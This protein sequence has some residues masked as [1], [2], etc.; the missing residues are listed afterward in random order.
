LPDK[1]INFRKSALIAAA[2]VALAACSNESNSASSD[3][4][5]QYV[6]A[7]SWQPAFCETA[8][9]KPECKS[10][11]AD[12]YD[13]SHFSLHGL[14]PQ[15][16]TNVYCGIAEAERAKDSNGRWRDLDAPLIE[17]PLWQDVQ[18]IM[19]GARSSLHKH[20]WIKHGTCAGVDINRYFARSLQL[21]EAINASGLQQL[22][23][24]NTGRTLSAEDI[25]TTFSQSFGEGAGDRLRVSCKRDGDTGRQLIVELTLGMGDPFKQDTVLADLVGAATSSEPGCPSG[26]VD[27]V[28]LQ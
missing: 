10:Q 22:F 23:V 20:E 14:W 15:P 19:P 18:R 7:F 12:R 24:D 1:V 4:P 26:M 3:Q 13:A 25:R 5:V 21:L 11:T 8:A 27:P 6:L 2:L 9:S 16:G 17:N 28:G